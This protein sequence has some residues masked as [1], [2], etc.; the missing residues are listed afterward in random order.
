MYNFENL[1]EV[2][3]IDNDYVSI[4]LIKIYLTEIIGN[5]VRVVNFANYLDALNYLVDIK[6]DLSPVIFIDPF[7]CNSENFFFLEEYKKLNLSYYVYIISV[8]I[9]LSDISMCLEYK[10]VI[11]YITKPIKL[12]DFINI[13]SELKIK[14]RWNFISV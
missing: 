9:L 14:E 4:A 11:K 1:N 5:S 6:G 8:S 7:S 12:M 10:F 3:V 2:I 13:L